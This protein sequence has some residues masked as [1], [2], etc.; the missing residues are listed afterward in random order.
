MQNNFKQL[1]D[2]IFK[3]DTFKKLLS[4]YDLLCKLNKIMY[5]VLPEDLSC[6]CK[7]TEL[8]SDNIVTMSINEQLMAYKLHYAKAQLM[9]EFSNNGINISGIKTRVT[10]NKP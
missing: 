2:I 3:S 5:S 1:S 10:P 9:K 8:D 4:N 6:Y 7:I